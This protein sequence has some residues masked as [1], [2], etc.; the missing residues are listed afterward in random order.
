MATRR[1][2]S[3]LLSGT[4][5][6]GVLPAALLFGMLDAGGKSMEREARFPPSPFSS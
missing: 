2:Q 3:R 6:L 5:P 4:N 1:L